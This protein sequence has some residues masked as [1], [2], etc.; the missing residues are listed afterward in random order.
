MDANEYK[1]LVIRVDGNLA[2]LRAEVV[3]IKAMVKETNGRVRTH[4]EDIASL[5]TSRKL[6]WYL[7]GGGVFSALLLKVLGV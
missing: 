1:E 3:D 7:T 5:K 4:G 2:F 6:F